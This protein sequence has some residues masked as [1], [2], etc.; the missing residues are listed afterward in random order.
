MPPVQKIRAARRLFAMLI[1]LKD[2][3]PWAGDGKA[4]WST[5]T[6]GRL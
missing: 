3:T 4:V 2:V 5:A 1:A 6:N